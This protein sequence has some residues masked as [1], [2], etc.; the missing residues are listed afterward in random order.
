MRSVVVLLVAAA[1]AWADLA[2]PSSG[3]PEPGGLRKVLVELRAAAVAK[4]V[5]RLMKRV[6]PDID[7]ASAVRAQVERGPC[8]LAHLI[9]I[10]DH[11]TCY[12]DF[13][14]VAKCERYL[15]K[16]TFEQITLWKTKAGW[17]LVDFV[18]IFSSGSDD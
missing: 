9:D 7:E 11:G 1:P 4:D 18:P 12:S 14:G 2:A 6:V 3:A 10:I 5:R 16:D 17:R 8:T 15:S 13:T